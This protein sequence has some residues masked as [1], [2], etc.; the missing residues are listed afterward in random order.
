M[1]NETLSSYYNERSVEVLYPPRKWDEPETKILTMDELV[2]SNRELEQ[3]A[4]AVSHDLQ[5]PLK[6]ISLYLQF[7]N[8]KYKGRLDDKENENMSSI[9]DKSERM[10]KLIQSMLDY[11]RVGNGN[12]QFTKFDSNVALTQAIENLKV[13][14]EENSAKI[15][16]EDCPVIMGDG[17]RL[18][19][20]FQNLI[21]NAIKFHKKGELPYIRIS[22]KQ[23]ENQ[24]LFSVEDNGIGVEREHIQDIFQILKRLHPQS[25]Y[26]GTGIGLALCKRIVE[27]HGGNIWVESEIGKGTTV[28]FNIPKI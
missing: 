2:R 7:L 12:L 14:I 5:E 16:C 6:L 8:R 3:F 9:L 1:R 27:S 10:Q 11:A 21:N 19:Q 13:T 4:F 26:A 25:E 20:L 22:V 28:Y 18:T 23:K 17:I 24:W 15:R